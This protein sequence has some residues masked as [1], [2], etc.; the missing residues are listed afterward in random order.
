MK[1]RSNFFRI[2]KQ[3]QRGLLLL[4]LIVLAVEILLLYKT[5]N[6][7]SQS[8]KNAQD[9][10][11]FQNQ[12]DSLKSIQKQ[13]ESITIY[14]FNPNYLT[15]YRGYILGLSPQEVQRMIDFRKQKK[16][17]NTAKEFQRITQISDSLLEHVSPYLKFPKWVSKSNKKFVAKPLIKKPLNTATAE[18]LK[19]VYG[20]GNVLADRIIQFRNV[21]GGFVLADQL[22]DVYGLEDATI[23]NILTKFEIK[24]P[25]TIQKININTASID[26]LDEVPYMTYSMA[27]DVV[28][29][30]SQHG[31]ITSFEEIQQLEGFSIKKTKR[32][33]LYLYIDN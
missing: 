4:I 12:I 29:Y 22:G 7:P 13:K 17:V 31:N 6:F 25:P 26:E 32:I 19:K 27:R 8:N 9:W 18:D 30:R 20:V 24:N 14:P 23:I 10:K 3:Q 21:I 16:F 1:P 28:I 11:R 15:Q 2:S 5:E 33:A